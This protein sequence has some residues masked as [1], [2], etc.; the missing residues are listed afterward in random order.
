MRRNIP[1]LNT[2]LIKKTNPEHPLEGIWTFNASK[3][4]KIR[5]AGFYHPDTGDVDFYTV[6]GLEY[7]TRES[8]REGFWLNLGE[9]IYYSLSDRT[10]NSLK[11]MRAPFK[12][13]S[14]LAHS[15]NP[16]K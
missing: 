16:L 7:R 14:I 12:Y 5:F 8:G 10:Y 6:T 1:G 3:A 9:K 15:T 2:V 13:Y 4:G 11:E